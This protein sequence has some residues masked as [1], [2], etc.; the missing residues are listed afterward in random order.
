MKAP[1][2]VDT[3]EKLAAP[4]RLVRRVPEPPGEDEDRST[5]KLVGRGKGVAGKKPLASYLVQLNRE[6]SD[7]IDEECERTGLSPFDVIRRLIDEARAASSK[8]SRRP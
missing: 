1:R 4:P 3:A 2:G 5:W 8:M 7:W 6:Q